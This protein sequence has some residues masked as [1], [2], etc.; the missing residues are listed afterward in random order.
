MH[1]SIETS[2]GGAAWE[3][4]LRRLAS[5][6]DDAARGMFFAGAL[7]VVGV[8]GGE[9]AMARCKGV[10]G[11]WDVNPLH[12]Y[13]I[14][15]FLR[16]VSTAARLLAPQLDDGFE[17]VLRRMG[18]QSTLDFLSSMFGKDLMQTAGGSPRKLLQSLGDSYRTAVSY[19][20]R[21][22]LWTGEKSVRFIMRRDFMPAAYHEGVLMGV[23]EAVGAQGVKVYGRQVALLDSEYEVSWK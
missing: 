20:E 21:Y 16:L 8:L 2:A 6:E 23:L 14:S 10:A 19:G 12:M 15:R 1:V 17:G 18:T 13:P 22:P 3:L 11:L 5:T 9:G 4:E 7:E